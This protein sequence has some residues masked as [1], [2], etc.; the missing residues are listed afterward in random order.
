MTKKPTLEELEKIL[1]EDPDRPIEIMPDGSIKVD[2]RKKG[3]G[4]IKT[5]RLNV[6]SSY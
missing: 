6:S 4:Y 2:R 1:L 3:K 5:N